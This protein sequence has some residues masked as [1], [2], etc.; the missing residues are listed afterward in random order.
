METKVR[1]FDEEL[2]K[3]EITIKDWLEIKILNSLKER[4]NVFVSVFN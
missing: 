3:L 2:A 4:Y 1:K